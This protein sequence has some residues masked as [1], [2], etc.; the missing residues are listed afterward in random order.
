[1]LKHKIMESVYKYNVYDIDIHK[2]TLLTFRLTIYGN[3]INE[4]VTCAYNATLVWQVPVRT[5]I[6]LS[7][8][9]LK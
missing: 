6:S 2:N 8:I 1:M 4:V 3:K 5:I 7:C 9:S